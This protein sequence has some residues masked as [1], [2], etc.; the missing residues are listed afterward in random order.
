MVDVGYKFHPMPLQW[1]K[2]RFVP[3][4]RKISGGIN[5]T[6]KLILGRVKSS[7]NDFLEPL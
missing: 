4:E 2:A 7:I 3:L 1:R 5:L 6:Y